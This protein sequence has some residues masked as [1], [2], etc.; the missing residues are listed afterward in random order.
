MSGAFMNKKEI[1]S[2]IISGRK[3]I[4][5]YLWHSFYFIP[6]NDYLQYTNKILPVIQ[7]ICT[8]I[9]HFLKK[10][11]IINCFQEFSSLSSSLD[12]LEKAN[13][14]FT[15][16]FVSGEK[17]K[18]REFLWRNEEISKEDIVVELQAVYDKYR[19]AKPVK[20]N[21]PIDNISME[22]FLLYKLAVNEQ[23]KDIISDELHLYENHLLKWAE[24]Y[25]KTQ[26]EKCSL[27][28]A[29]ALYKGLFIFSRIYLLHDYF[30]LKEI[31]GEI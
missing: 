30:F 23:S 14:S 13:I 5:E 8:G 4:L 21:L 6:D 29:D 17:V 26:E 27:K 18:D 11:E 7:D 2:S 31:Y 22:I 28:N 12:I 20:I 19:I 3:I 10:N 15:K 16:F 24:Q 25:F 9:E 1:E